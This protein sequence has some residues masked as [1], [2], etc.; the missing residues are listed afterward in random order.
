[1]TQKLQAVLLP[2][3]VLPA[4]LAYPAAVEALGPEVDARYKELEVYATEAPPQGDFLKR[5]V[6]GI[7][8][9]ADAAGFDR[10]HLVGYSAGGAS[11]LAFCAEHPERVLSLTLNE[12]GWIGRTGLSREEAEFREEIGPIAQMSPEERFPAF[13]QI[14]LAPGVAPPP[15]PEGPAPP[16]MGQRIAA[17]PI[18]AESTRTADID[19]S[20]LRDF[21][22]PVLYMLGGRSSA[23]YRAMADRLASI[24]SDFTLKVFDQRHHFDPPHRAEPD[25]FAAELRRHWTRASATT[26][27]DATV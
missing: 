16:W 20:A 19:H 2:G 7:G 6:A 15:P 3:G 1:M 10:F 24:F 11:A 21:K 17:F 22:R 18:F 26:M 27:T 14:Q 8:A 5:E 13:V 9:F 23:V 25:A 12:P 4:D